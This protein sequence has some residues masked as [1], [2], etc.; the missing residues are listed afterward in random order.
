MSFRDHICPKINGFCGRKIRVHRQITQTS[1]IVHQLHQAFKQ[2]TK[3]HPKVV[4]LSIRQQLIAASNDRL[5]DGH[6]V[7]LVATGWPPTGGF[8][9]A[10]CL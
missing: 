8:C 7:D 9:L 6:L 4:L 1:R 10:L 3:N 5:F 2:A